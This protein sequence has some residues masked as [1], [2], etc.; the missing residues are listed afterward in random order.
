MFIGKKGLHPF[1][2]LLNDTLAGDGDE[3]CQAYAITSAGQLRAEANLPA[4]LK[5]AAGPATRMWNRLLWA[6]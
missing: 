2:P 1:A 4:I 3:L 5:L 6:L